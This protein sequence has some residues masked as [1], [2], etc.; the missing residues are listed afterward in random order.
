MNHKYKAGRRV[1]NWRVGVMSIAILWC[2][3]TGYYSNMDDTYVAEKKQDVFMKPIVVVAPKVKTTHKEVIESKIAHY[4]PRNAKVMVAIA[5]AESGLSME[6]KGYNCFYNHSQTKVYR[7]R[8]KGSYSSACLPKD[9][10]YAYSVDCFALQRNYQGQ[11]CPKG[12]TLDQHLQDVAS[13][14]RVQGLQAWAAFNNKSYE[15]HL[16][17]K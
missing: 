8:V 17:S 6:A 9:R 11:E 16:A 10:V 12:V 5:K 13:L 1:M 14:S 3:V 2:A 4:F 15:K 7:E